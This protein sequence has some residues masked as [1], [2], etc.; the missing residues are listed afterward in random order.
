MIY[1]FPGIHRGIEVSTIMNTP[2]MASIEQDYSPESLI[3]PYEDFNT[4]Q[5]KITGERFPNIVLEL[6]DNCR[7]CAM[8]FN[9]RGLIIN[10]PIVS[11]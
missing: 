8:C 5:Q 6:C 3:I 10:C 9:A 7:W 4:E 2:D 11:A 1:L